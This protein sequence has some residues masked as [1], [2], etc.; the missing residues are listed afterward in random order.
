[1]LR[2]I[3]QLTAQGQEARLRAILDD[4]IAVDSSINAGGAGDK[5]NND[6]NNGVLSN[7]VNCTQNGAVNFNAGGS[8]STLSRPNSLA[9]NGESLGLKRADLLNAVLPVVGSN[10]SLQRLYSEYRS[11]A[12]RY[13]SI[14][15]IQYLREYNI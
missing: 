2:L 1:M 5:D 7:G 12:V 9:R 11:V 3:K 14:H 10:L 6:G 8:S 4:L 13:P 15:N